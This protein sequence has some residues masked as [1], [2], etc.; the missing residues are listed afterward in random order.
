DSHRHSR[1]IHSCGGLGRALVA[2]P[3][4]LTVTVAATA[5]AVLLS[6]FLAAP[7]RRPAG[8]LALVNLHRLTGGPSCGLA[9]DIQV[10]PDGA[11]L[12][13]ADSSGRLDGFAALAGF[14]PSSPPP[15]P[16]GTGRSAELWGSLIGGPRHTGTMTSPWFQLPALGGASGVAVSVSG[17]TDGGNK[18][19]LEFGRAGPA[20]VTTLGARVPFDWVR[21]SLDYL[22]DPKDYRYTDGPPDYRSWRSIGLDAAQVPAGADRIRIHAVDATTDP[23][24]WLAVTG[25]RLRSVVGLTEFLAGRGPVLVS[26]PQAF[27]FPCVR[28]I[29]EVADGLAGAPRVVIEAPRRLGP[30]SSITTGQ[31]QGGD[32]AALR[33]FGQLYEVPTRLAGHPDVDWGTLELSG[34]TGAR[35]AYQRGTTRTRTWGWTGR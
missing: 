34:D 32:F 5:V 11:V 20:D 8:S 12:T 10:L 28:N 35:D 30:L 23:E 3:A 26:W 27:L 4:V 25:P 15:D 13:P 7:L 31:A 22:S 19:V 2:A 18:L 9:D 16:P 33:P 14:D 21:P 17:R 24:G 29:P 1:V 6:S